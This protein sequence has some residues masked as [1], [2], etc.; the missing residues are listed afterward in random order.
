MQ[1]GWL[2]AIKTIN[3]ELSI[4]INVYQAS[5]WK[6][7]PWIVIVMNVTTWVL[8]LAFGVGVC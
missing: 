1:E 2:V 5:L 3:M 7:K 4:T 8:N 6:Y